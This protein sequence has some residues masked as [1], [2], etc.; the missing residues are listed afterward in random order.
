VAFEIQLETPTRLA[1][2][3]P[4]VD[5]LVAHARSLPEA[6]RPRALPPSARFPKLRRSMLLRRE[7]PIFFTLVA[8][9]LTR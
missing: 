7:K 2:L 8:R 5:E 4:A 6:R 9:V 3:V 1:E